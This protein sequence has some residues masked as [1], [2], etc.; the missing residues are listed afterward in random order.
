MEHIIIEGLFVTP[1]KRI[2]H[3]QGDVF[4][5]IKK[6]DP[7]FVQFGEAYFST[8]KMDQIKPWKKH[9][10]MTLNLV[11]PLG[12]IRFVIY[13][14]R[15]E[16]NTKGNFFEIIISEENYCRL[17][18]PPN[19]WMAFQGIGNHENILLNIADYE[20][21]PNEILRCNLDSIKFDW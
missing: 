12:K 8:I 1:L 7:G 14:D 6:S 16:S 20:H 3:P 11:V 21:D 19:V 5:G 18:V 13:D 2:Y 9:S 15:T 17:T 10:I 4:H